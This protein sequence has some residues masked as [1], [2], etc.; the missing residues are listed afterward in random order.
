M[1][2]SDIRKFGIGKKL[3][4]FYIYFFGGKEHI[5]DYLHSK[6]PFLL[7]PSY[8]ENIVI[9]TL[10]A[11]TYLLPVLSHGSEIFAKCACRDFNKLL[12]LFVLSI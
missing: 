6:G 10:F 1:K 2:W 7:L 11:K 3:V 9:R 12:F 8:Q 4:R 5:E